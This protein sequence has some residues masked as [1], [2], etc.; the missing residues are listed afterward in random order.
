MRAAEEEREVLQLQARPATTHTTCAVLQ[1]YYH[2]TVK[3]T[4]SSEQGAQIE[5]LFQQMS[6][7]FG[8]ID[9]AAKAAAEVERTVIAKAEAAAAAAAAAAAEAAAAQA[10]REAAAAAAN[11]P[12]GSAP[13]PA[14]AAAAAPAGAAEPKQPPAGAAT[15]G[16]GKGG[17]IVQGAGGKV[18]LQK[19][20]TVEDCILAKYKDK[21][22]AKAAKKDDSADEEDADV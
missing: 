9:A 10:A 17:K 3:K 16:T 21:A 5:G 12:A 18:Q 19:K 7:L 6:V 2:D 1:S 11:Q 4:A 20:F 8:T 13:A 14:A 22:T 15:K